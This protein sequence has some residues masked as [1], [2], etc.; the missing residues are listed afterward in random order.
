VKRSGRDEPMWVAIYKCMEATLGIPVY[1]YLYLKLAKTLSFLLSLMFSLQ[2]NQRRGQNRLCL[3]TG[4]NGALREGEV[5]QT[6]Y[7]HVSKCKNDKMRKEKKKAHHPFLIT[8][9]EN[10]QLN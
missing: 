6:M 4:R 8:Y 7:T 10:Y 5:A 9:L 2:Q 1:S 3:E